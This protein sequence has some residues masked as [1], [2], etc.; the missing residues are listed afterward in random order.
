MSV[1]VFRLGDVVLQSGAT[2]PA[3]QVTY[4][5]YGKLNAA[6]DNAVLLPT[7]YSG[8]HTDTEL[9]LAPG[10]ALDTSKYFIVV[11]NMFGNGLSSSPSNAPP[12]CD[13]A[14]FPGVTLYDN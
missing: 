10:R 1:D 9:M 12:P 4:K 6:R 13:R 2:L 14:R 7:Y 3:A 5:T 8:Q 11:P